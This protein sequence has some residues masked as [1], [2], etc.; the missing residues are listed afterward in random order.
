MRDDA[1]FNVECINQILPRIVIE[2]EDRLVF[3]CAGSLLFV[4]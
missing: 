2:M 3:L 4:S 1:V